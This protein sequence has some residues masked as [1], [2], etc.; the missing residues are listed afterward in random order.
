MF[1]ANNDPNVSVIIRRQKNNSR[2]L[3]DR[4]EIIRGGQVVKMGKVS[5]FVAVITIY[6]ATLYS[7]FCC[8][9]H[10]IYSAEILLSGVQTKHPKVYY[11]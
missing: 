6:L 3:R 9:S 1:K 8:F 4:G 5:S 2:S 10:K 7:T 11:F